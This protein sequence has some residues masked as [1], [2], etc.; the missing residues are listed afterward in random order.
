MSRIAKK[1]LL[2]PD[3]VTV[4]LKPGVLHAKGPMGE[5]S[6]FLPEFVQVTQAGNG[7][8][9]TVSRPALKDQRTMWG[10]TASLIKNAL[11]GVKEGYQ[12]QLEIMG[13][14]FKAAL[15]GRTL[16]LNIGFSHPV[17]YTL[18]QGITASIEK[19][20]ITIYG[21]EK[22]SVGEVAAQLYHIKPPD[23]YK[24]VGIRYVGQV[25]KLKPGKQAKTAGAPA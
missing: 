10:T 20:V 16:T 7:L 5:S 15:T 22:Q 17:V 13:T 24:G 2:I 21:I 1:P 8:T 25:I 23:P 12:K 3:A 11:Q 19:T 6:V 4:S 14:G 9:V 18:P